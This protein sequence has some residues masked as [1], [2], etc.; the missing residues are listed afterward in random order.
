MTIEY[1][2]QKHLPSLRSL[3]KEAFGDGDTYLNRFFGTAYSPDRARCVTDADGEVTAALYWF[4]A[5]L[6]GEKI[7]YLYAIATRRSHRGRGLC[8]S[9]MHDTHAILRARGYVAALLVP[10]EPSLFDFY[11]RV[12]Y[13]PCV[14]MQILAADAADAPISLR[15]VSVQ[16]YGEWRA[17]CLPPHGVHPSPEMLDLLAAQEELYRGEGILLAAHAEGD[18]LAATELLGDT[19]HAGRILRALGCSRGR[20]RVAGG[21][22]PFAAYLPLCDDAPAPPSHFSLAFD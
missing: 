9:L 2:S 3:W 16:E 15:R 4:D 8:Q 14:P 13:A 10:S 22:T 17:K 19:A 20:F 12:G 1:P 6:D 5:T 7:A 11:A 18:T 21:K